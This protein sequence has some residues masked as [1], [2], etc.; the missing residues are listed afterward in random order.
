MQASSTAE[1]RPTSPALDPPGSRRLPG[2]PAPLIIDRTGSLEHNL[3][4]SRRSRLT[5]EVTHDTT[6]AVVQPSGGADAGLLTGSILAARLV[7]FADCRAMRCRR[8][9]GGMRVARMRSVVVMRMPRGGRTLSTTAGNMPG[10]RRVARQTRH[11]GVQQRPPTGHQVTEGQPV[12]N[13][14]GMADRHHD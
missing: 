1:W 4:T 7:H 10:M 3:K 12:C 14:P 9:V 5:E 6:G 2:R 8:L 13:P 11:M